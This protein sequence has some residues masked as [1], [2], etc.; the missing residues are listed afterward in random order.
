MLLPLVLLY[1]L[2]TMTL[3]QFIG[4]YWGYPFDYCLMPAARASDQA[5]IYSGNW[6][7]VVATVVTSTQYSVVSVLFLLPCFLSFNSHSL[8]PCIQT[9]NRFMGD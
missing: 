5:C 1:T 7:V 3:C 2:S 9:V 4:D 8:H 6:L